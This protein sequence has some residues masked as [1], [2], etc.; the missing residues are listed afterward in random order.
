MTIRSATPEDVS[1][2][3]PMVRKIAA[4]HAA[5]DSAKYQL[6][7]DPAEPYDGWLRSRAV[8]PRSVFLVAESAKDSGAP[9]LVGFL[10]AGVEK[11]I[12]IYHLREF[13]LIHDLWVDEDY[14]H[15][16]LARQMVTLALER[17]TQI[18][19]AQVRLHAAWDNAPARALFDRC[20]FRPSSV[21][22]LCGTGVS[23]V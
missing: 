15:E 20:G 17:F 6:R 19:V 13:G 4:F 2:V 11:E 5:M 18:G 10:I 8:D 12:P 16:G 7:G 23:P 21:E 1:A 22:M 14:R 3:L 9:P